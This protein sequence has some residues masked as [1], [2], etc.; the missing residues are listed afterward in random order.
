MMVLKPQWMSSLR[1]PGTA[2]FCSWCD[3]SLTVQQIKAEPV[4]PLSIKAPE[5]KVQTG[6]ILSYQLYYIL[7]PPV[8]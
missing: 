3:Q 7:S 2:E 4:S 6:T 8:V 1:R 5:V